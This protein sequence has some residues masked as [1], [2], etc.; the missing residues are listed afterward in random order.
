MMLANEQLELLLSKVRRP[1]RYIGGE[2]NSANKPWDSAEIRWCL[3]F[4]D[5]YE[6]GMSHIGLQIIYSILNGMDNVLADRA[7]TPWIDMEAAMRETKSPLWGLES[8]REL[9]D[10]DIIGITLPYEL[11]Y[12]NILTILNLA[13][14]PFFASERDEKYPLI[15]GGGVGAFNPEP[16]APFFDAIL[17]GDGEEAVKEITDV[18]KGWKQETGN[19]KHDLLSRLSKIKGMYAP[20]CHC[21]ESRA[22]RGTTKQSPEID[23]VQKA[24]V[25]DITSASYPKKWVVPFMQVVHD[26]VGV[27]IQ[28]GCARGCRFCQAG[29][30]YRPVRQRSSEKI[31]NLSKEGLDL[32]GHE[33]L[34][35]LSL[36]AGDYEG[37]PD[38]LKNIASAAADKW[39]NINLPS[40]RVESLTKDTIGVLKRSLHGGFTLAPEA[41][42]E[43]LRLVINKGNTEADLLATI[44]RVVSAGW[45][46]LKLYFMIGLPTETIEDVKA[47]AELVNKACDCGRRIRRDITITASVSTFVPKPHTPFQWAKQISINE[48]LEK[49]DML[50]GLLRRR[51][52]ELKWHNARLS[53]LEGVFSRGDKRLSSAIVEAWNNGARF[54]AWD[55]NFKFDIWMEA[56]KRCGIDPHEYIERER[57]PEE[58]MPWNHLYSELDRKFL[59]DEYSKALSGAPTEDCVKHKCSGCGVCDFKEVK[60]VV[61]HIQ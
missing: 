33:E 22:C 9:H 34:S 19:R 25:P 20:A 1:S 43:R 42:T 4:P 2:I 3:A 41:G 54:D 21:E 15:I 27:E 13:G 31:E 6:I 55:E 48:T 29:F 46:Q 40:L 38:T 28:R 52:I 61:F 32:T 60:N 8:L 17:L 35:L 14:I 26:R 16:V 56:F 58:K 37:L 45:R 18:Y 7:F 51:G 44:E 10:F 49:Q 47:I 24:I 59:R 36:S 39:T 23:S 5:V 50:K 53:F 57:T 11:T 12:T 30:I